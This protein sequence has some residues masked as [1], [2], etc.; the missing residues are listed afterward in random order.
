MTDRRCSWT[1]ASTRPDA[2]ADGEPTARGPAARRRRAD[3]GPARGACC[4]SRSGRCRGREIARLAGVDRA[5][6]DERLGDLEVTLRGRGHPRRPRRA[7]AWSSR[8]PPEAGALIAPLR[9]RGR[10]P[11]VARGARDARDRRLPPADHQGRH[12]ADPR[13]RLGL[14]GP[15]AAPPPAHR[16]AGPLRGARAARS[17]TAP[18]F[19]FL[20]RFGLTSLDELP[21]LDLEIAARLVDGDGDEAAARRST[22][23]GRGARPRRADCRGRPIPPA[24]ADR[25]PR[26]ASRRSSR[27]PA[28][29]RGAAPTRW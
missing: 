14:H 1:R 10:G 6:V 5:T 26:S 22:R 8:R 3:R 23:R 17:C 4:S 11:A 12:R 20:E 24:R 25:V 16:R 19:E 9:R 29:R 7:T 2:D 18:G 27:R 13:R 15:G 21:P 28:S